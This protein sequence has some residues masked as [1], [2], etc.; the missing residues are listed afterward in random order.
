MELIQGV[1]TQL[2]DPLVE[3]SDQISYM[4]QYS[5]AE[6]IQQT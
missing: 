2:L 5:F 3:Q 4:I 1:R 6:K